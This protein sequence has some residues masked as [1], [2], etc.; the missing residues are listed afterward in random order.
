[1]HS[2]VVGTNIL[3]DSF[4]FLNKYIYLLIPIFIVHILS[5]VFE[6]KTVFTAFGFFMQILVGGLLVFLYK[7]EDLSFKLSFTIFRRFV[8]RF[9]GLLVYIVIIW[10]VWLGA[11]SIFLK[12]IFKTSLNINTL[13]SFSVNP[14]FNWYAILS[15]LNN[16]IIFPVIICAQMIL[17]YEDCYVYEAI[18]EGYVFSVKFLFI[19]FL[20]AAVVFEDGVPM[21]F[22]KTMVLNG[23]E[24]FT[25]NLIFKLIFSYMHFLSFVIVLSLY[26]N[27][28]RPFYFKSLKPAIEEL[29]A[30]WRF[31]GEDAIKKIENISKENSHPF[32][33]KMCET[34]LKKM[35]I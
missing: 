16:L 5:S 9:F 1:M 6:N 11:E 3:K 20:L 30:L 10:A 8:F 17:F 21:C 22:I 32:I 23:S 25:P 15:Y 27:F 18:R 26:H 12:L 33:R 35:R 13:S 34:Y 14:Q 2:K 7:G 31:G 28:G 19:F 29:Q 4:N 24:S